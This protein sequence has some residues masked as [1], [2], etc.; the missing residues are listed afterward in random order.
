MLTYKQIEIL[1]KDNVSQ[2][3]PKKVL[4]EY[5]QYEI[6]DSIFKQKDS[7]NLSFMGGTA[8]RIGY[9]GNRF[10]EDL[11][12]D[13]FGLSFDDFTSLLEL[14]STD[15]KLKGFSIE[16]R[17]VEAGAYHC[18]IKFPNILFENKISNI[19]GEKILVRIDTV[20]KE[21]IFTPQILTLNRFDVY[22]DILINPTNI[23]LSQKLLAIYGRKREKGRDFYDVSFLY[24]VTD[25]DFDYIEKITK[26]SKENFI[27]E[28]LT[29]C[30]K[31]NYKN[32]TNDVLPFL[33]KPEQS[34]RV[35]NFMNFIQQKL[36]S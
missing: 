28:F 15:M 6:L 12:F 24:S 19:K 18:Y 29:R 9:K 11:D 25:P 27:K 5:L 1:Y 7:R 36:V 16:T 10:S 20:K 32:L 35:L 31:F 34:T 14:A 2:T 21:K 33:I 13:N 26:M 8:I 17:L 3:S 22:R 4:V 30:E 23:L